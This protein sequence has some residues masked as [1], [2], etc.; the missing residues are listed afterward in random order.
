[1]KEDDSICKLKNITQT[2]IQEK[3]SI[4]KERTKNNHA[5]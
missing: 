3:S 1:M 5:A 2:D 4:K